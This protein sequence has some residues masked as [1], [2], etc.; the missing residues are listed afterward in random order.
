MAF[1]ELWGHD[2]AAGKPVKILV[3]SG[4]CLQADVLAN[5][6]PPNASLDLVKHI[7]LAG[8]IDKT[9]SVTTDVDIVAFG[10]GLRSKVHIVSMSGFVAGFSD[11]GFL[12]YTYDSGGGPQL[13]NY[14]Y[15]GAVNWVRE[16]SNPAFTAETGFI[17]NLYHVYRWVSSADYNMRIIFLP[18]LAADYGWGVRLINDTGAS[19]RFYMMYGYCKES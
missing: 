10:T 6:F 7:G 16:V 17:P 11:I 5:V 13:Y 4:G 19:R 15:A 3:D 1:V 18:S 12:V 9:V 14:H 2:A 8:S